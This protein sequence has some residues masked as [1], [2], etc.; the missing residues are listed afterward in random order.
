MA[1]AVT[2]VFGANSTQFQAELA[3][4]QT[5]AAAS[6]RRIGADMAGAHGGH[7]G[8]TGIVRESAVI[9]REI[10]MG[11]GFGRILASMTL[12]A[13]YMNTAKRNAEQGIQAAE[14]LADGYEKMA[15]K[16]RLA[17]ISALKKAEASAVAAE[18]DGFE[19]AA[20]IAAADANA[21]EAKNAELAA[22]ALEQ[23]AAAAWAAAEADEAAAAAAVTAGGAF[24][25]MLGTLGFFGLL[26]VIIAELYVVVKSLT[27]ILN[28]SAN[29][30]QKAAEWANA[31]RLAIWE[32]IEAM[33]KLKDASENFTQSL[34][35]MNTA[36]DRS[37]ELAREA[38]EAFKAESEAKEKLYDVG[39]KSKLL[40]VD[41]DEKKGLI[42]HRDAIQK[43]AAI[44]T[45]AVADKAAA[46]QASLDGEAKIAA[47]AAAKAEKDKADAQAAAQAADDKINKSPEG[48]KRAAML[49]Q[50]EK[51]LAASKSEAE[52]AEK[53]K[54]EFNKGGS[55]ILYSSSLK[56]R[57]EAYGGNKDKAAALNETA[58][59]LANAA[60]S[61]EIRVNSL[62]RFMKPEEI[63]AA[64]AS[65]VAQERTNSALTLK[66]EAR[67]TATAA[68]TNKKN[69]PAEV[70]AEQA[71]IKKKKELDL[72][73]GA[74][75]AKGYGN[76]NSNQKI[77]A[78]AA[79]APILLQQLKSLQAIQHNTAPV[80]P[81][82]NHPPG[83]RK[84]QLGTRPNYAHGMH[85]GIDYG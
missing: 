78:Y 65:S 83:P 58:E 8:Q 14:M 4:M 32:E 29:M 27:E 33:E 23:K 3:R 84:P 26:L 34:V 41:I 46:K 19:D 61:A 52:A 70:A 31:H 79:T 5:M 77:G 7:A 9:G 13:Q 30:Q 80:H 62:K 75:E 81:P 72:L 43:K 57:L 63:A 21:L 48:K 18:M 12:L 37:V 42:S 51:D 38:A 16:A 15:V 68:T 28:R 66:E 44:E 36:K 60:A 2:V 6:G 17:A 59:S 71:E 73:P 85:N 54:I 11:R 47:A 76:L 25:A 82:A 55:N 67:K 69:L 49:A 35:K 45:Q 10:A 24:K 50:A 40:D 64:T 20:S 22:V 1:S 53:D 74:A 56:S 39:V